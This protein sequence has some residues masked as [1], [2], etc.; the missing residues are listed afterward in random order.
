M[1]MVAQ[2]IARQCDVLLAKWCSPTAEK[3]LSA[4]GVGIVT[5]MSGTVA[6]VL[7]RFERE[8]LQGHMEKPDVALPAW[9]MDRRAAMQALQSASRQIMNLLPV[10]IGVIFLTG[11]FMAFLSAES[12]ASL[13]SGGMGWDAF[14]GA[15]LGSLFAGNP[16]N[17]YIIGGQ[18]LEMGISLVAVTAFICSW[19]SVGIVQLP[20]EIAALG[21]KFAALRNASCFVLSMGVS[22]GIAFF[23]RFFEV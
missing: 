14:C 18:L 6:E 20:A 16:V 3:Y 22:L 10:M 9:K 11:L 21:W 1:Q 15:C 4:H 12:L 5:G 7:D 23:L 17:S 2:I 19:V 8:N 13:F